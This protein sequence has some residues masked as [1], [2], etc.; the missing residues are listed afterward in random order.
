[1]QLMKTMTY[2]DM[3]EP[4]GFRPLENRADDIMKVQYR[5]VPEMVTRG[6]QTHAPALEAVTG[7]WRRSVSGL[8]WYRGDRRDFA[9]RPEQLEGPGAEEESV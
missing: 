6:N 8:G 3:G 5:N 2:Q 7:G 4:C 1:M 9:E